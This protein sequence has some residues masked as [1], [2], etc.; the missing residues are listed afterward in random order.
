QVLI[1]LVG[2]DF[3]FLP[4]PHSY[5]LRSSPEIALQSIEEIISPEAFRT[6]RIIRYDGGGLPS[7]LIAG[8]FTFATPES[9][10]LVQ[11]LP[12]MIQVSAS[13]AHSPLWFQSTL[14]FIAAE[15]AQDLPGASVIVDR[16]AE[17]LFVQA[18]RMR[19]Q[20]PY[21]NGNPSWLRGL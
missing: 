3:V 13:D 19:I 12:P 6:A 4:S 1:P 9:E 5:S 21:P 11:Y 15:L 10:W 18:M 17:V 2:G 20:L 14:Q 16:L 7:S 8:C